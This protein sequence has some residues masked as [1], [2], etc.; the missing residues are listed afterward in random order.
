MAVSPACRGPDG[1][2]REDTWRLR[3]RVGREQSASD[4]TALAQLH[5]VRF[6]RRLWGF[7]EQL[8]L[9]RGG[10]MLDGAVNDVGASVSA[11]CRTVATADGSEHQQSAK[12]AVTAC[13]T[14]AA[15][16]SQQEPAIGDPDYDADP[17]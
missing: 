9:G 17:P 4:A 3:A 13:D 5:R 1:R 10:S 2:A 7:R 14:R 8:Q 11:A 15:A 16:Y 6:D 12:V